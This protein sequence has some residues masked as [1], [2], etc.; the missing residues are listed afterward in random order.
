MVIILPVFF[1]KFIHD[2]ITV[3]LGDGEICVAFEEVAIWESVA[4]EEVTI[5]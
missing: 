4:F 3:T 2:G 1:P 5:E